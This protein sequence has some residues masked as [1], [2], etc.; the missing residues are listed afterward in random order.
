MALEVAR[1]LALVREARARRDLCQGQLG[2]R[3]Q[4][5]LG[6]ID[7][8]G[9]ETEVTR[10]LMKALGVP[11]ARRAVKARGGAASKPRKKGAGSA[12]KAKARTPRAKRRPASRRR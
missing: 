3:L 8:A 1:E 4:E 7:A 9:D 12:S 11:A 10:R 2:P 6:P 5:V